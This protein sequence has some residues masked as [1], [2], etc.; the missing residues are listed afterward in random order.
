MERAIEA[1]EE[2]EREISSDKNISADERNILLLRLERVK[3]TPIWMKFKFYKDFY[4]GVS[5]DDE[6][7]F[8]LEILKLRARIGRVLKE[9]SIKIEDYIKEK[10]NI[11]N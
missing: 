1:I 6:K 10:Y 5:E 2:G 4:P 3:F 11:S 8:A 9:E 7:K